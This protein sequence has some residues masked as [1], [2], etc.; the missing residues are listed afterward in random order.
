[1]EVSGWHHTQATLHP[2]KNPGTHWIWC[3]EGPTAG[4]YVLEKKYLPIRGF[5]QPSRY[6]DYVVHTPKISGNSSWK[7]ASFVN[8]FLFLYNVAAARGFT[9]WFDC[10]C[11][12]TI[13]VRD[14]KFGVEIDYEL[15]CT[16]RVKP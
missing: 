6:T 13:G 14:A 15:S 8:V 7:Y 12:R 2:V 1:M 9:F 3:W 4:L 11:Y 16:V 10:D 5:A